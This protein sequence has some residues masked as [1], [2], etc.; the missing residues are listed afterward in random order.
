[1]KIFN[2][3]MTTL[4]VVIFLVIFI[5]APENP[6]DLKSGPQEGKDYSISV[7]PLALNENNIPGTTI[8]LQNKRKTALQVESIGISCDKINYMEIPL[9]NAWIYPKVKVTINGEFP[10]VSYD[11]YSCDPIFDTHVKFASD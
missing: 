1:M 2:A 10:D 4:A 11:L 3:I 5:Y 9:N 8:L 7:T 6:L